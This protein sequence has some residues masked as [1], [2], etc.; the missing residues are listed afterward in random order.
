MSSEL[1]PSPEAGPQR[2]PWFVA[3]LN[4][5]IIRAIEQEGKFM[6]LPETPDPYHICDTEEHWELTRYVDYSEENPRVPAVQA[7]RHTGGEP[8]GYFYHILFPGARRGYTVARY[9]DNSS[10]LLSSCYIEGS[11]D[12]GADIN[13]YQYMKGTLGGSH[14]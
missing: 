7:R 2:N 4:V 6:T 14:E 11:H 13:I 8:E 9:S 12:E 3:E 10:V 1:Y 5:E